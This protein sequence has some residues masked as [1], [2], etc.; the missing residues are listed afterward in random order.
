MRTPLCYRQAIRLLLGSLLFGGTICAD[1]PPRSYSPR[2]SPE[3][4]ELVGRHL[5]EKAESEIRSHSNVCLV[6]FSGI[7]HTSKETAF[8]GT[9]RKSCRGKNASEGDGVICLSPT[10]APKA[11]ILDEPAN[12]YAFV[13]FNDANVCSKNRDWLAPYTFPGRRPRVAWILTGNYLKFPTKE[14]T[15]GEH[16]NGKWNALETGE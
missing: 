8:V 7:V 4:P 9:V 6:H 12:F 5:E 10:S 13:L 14:S 16:L 1:L 2:P 11:G 3:G 15:I